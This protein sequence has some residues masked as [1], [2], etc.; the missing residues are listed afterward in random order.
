MGFGGAGGLACPKGVMTRRM[1]SPVADQ[2][3]EIPSGKIGDWL[4]AAMAVRFHFRAQREFD[5]FILWRDRPITDSFKLLA[6]LHP[7]CLDF[8]YESSA[9]GAF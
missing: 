5:H 3:L 1:T 6:L 7:D 4:I 9:P 8:A 2:N